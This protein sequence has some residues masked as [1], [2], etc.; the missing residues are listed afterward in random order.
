MFGKNFTKIRIDSSLSKIKILRRFIDDAEQCSKKDFQ[1]AK[2]I[3][4]TNSYKNLYNADII[5]VCLPT[6]IDHRKIPDLKI[7]KKAS[8]QLAKLLKK[9][10]I[11]VYES[12]VYPGLTE[13][14]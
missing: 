5:I 11:V 6:P 12:T 4:F 14:V 3:K 13:E 10:S 7:L 2:K 8:K 1:A 9:D